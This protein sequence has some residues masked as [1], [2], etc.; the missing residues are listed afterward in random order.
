LRAQRQKQLENDRTR[1]RQQIDQLAASEGRIQQAI[2]TSDVEIDRLQKKLEAADKAAIENAK[3]G[4]Q[5]S[6]TPTP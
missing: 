2:A 5:P 3:T 6:P 1:S 4:S